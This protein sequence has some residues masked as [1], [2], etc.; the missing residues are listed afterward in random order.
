MNSAQV[1][2]PLNR[3]ASLL[4]TEFIDAGIRPCLGHR[5]S[6]RSNV[7]TFIVRLLAG[8]LTAVGRTTDA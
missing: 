7:R 2:R 4:G 6:C 8:N 5:R 3:K 1:G